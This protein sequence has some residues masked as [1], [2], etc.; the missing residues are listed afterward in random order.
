MNKGVI[1]AIACFSFAFVFV[2]F[3]NPST[4]TLPSQPSKS[5]EV[6]GEIICLPHKNSEG[7]QTLECAYGIRDS[8]TGLNYALAYPTGE[9]PPIQTG[10][11]V[12]IRGDFS[13][14]S[15]TNYDIVGKIDVLSAQD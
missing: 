10:D 13:P 5:I 9:L 15:E 3:A 14:V 6:N 7:P 1:I 11:V 12:V 4:E 8:K 2:M